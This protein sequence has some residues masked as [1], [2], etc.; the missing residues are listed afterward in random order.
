M[1]SYRELYLRLRAASLA[2]WVDVIGIVPVLFFGL[3]VLI[4]FGKV[5]YSVV[6]WFEL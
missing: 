2:I 5:N 6:V 3:L 1:F 4:D